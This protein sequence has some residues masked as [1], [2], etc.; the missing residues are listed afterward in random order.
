MFFKI[1][2][3]SIFCIF[4]K[5]LKSPP[6]FYSWWFW[7]STNSTGIFTPYYLDANFRSNKFKRLVTNMV[8]QFHTVVLPL[9]LRHGVSL[10]SLAH[11]TTAR[12]YTA[13]SLLQRHA[14]LTVSVISPMLV[15]QVPR[16]LLYIL[17]ATVLH[18]SLSTPRFAPPTR[19]T[20][21]V[22]TV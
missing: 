19:T 8:T 16:S 14:A 11:P 7:P 13:S 20:Y 17:T 10:A 4:F 2:D 6:F 12:L 22:V 9:C 5:Y 18:N 3:V 1:I 15:H 21:A